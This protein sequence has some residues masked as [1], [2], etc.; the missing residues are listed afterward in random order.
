MS[1]PM[2]AAWRRLMKHTRNREW[3]MDHG[4]R[5]DCEIDQVVGT[6]W[7]RQTLLERIRA[8]NVYG[9]DVVVGTFR[10]GMLSFV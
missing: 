1:P 4:S 9:G 6:Y 10:A 3:F 2:K 5:C 7:D 8:K